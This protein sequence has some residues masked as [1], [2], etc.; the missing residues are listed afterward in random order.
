ME[1]ANYE[2]VLKTIEQKVLNEAIDF[3][4]GIPIFATWARVGLAKL[5]YLFHKQDYVKHRLVY[6][7]GDPAT[8]VYLVKSG[9]FAIVTPLP[10]LKLPLQFD[11]QP[12]FN[13]PSRKTLR[14]ALFNPAITQK[15]LPKPQKQKY[16]SVIVGLQS[17]VEIGWSGRTLRL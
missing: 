16:V 9:Q 3:L 11:L 6:Q 7:V 2:K 14:D 12:Y 5:N 17:V 8:H 1:R 10:P 15:L 13:S 4:Q